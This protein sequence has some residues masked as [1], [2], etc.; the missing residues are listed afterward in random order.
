[1]ELEQLFKPKMIKV[2]RDWKQ[3]STHVIFHW[4]CIGRHDLFQN[5]L[6]DR[7]Q[8]ECHVRRLHTRIHAHRLSLCTA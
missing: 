3:K 7:L 6:C 2:E 5:H 1:M 8:Y 4:L